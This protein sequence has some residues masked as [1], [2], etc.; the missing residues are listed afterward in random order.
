MSPQ[1]IKVQKKIKQKRTIFFRKW[2]RRIGFTAALFLINLAVTGIILIH[3]EFMSLHKKFISNSLL[4]DWYG[5]KSPT[6]L[7][8][9]KFSTLNFCK[10]ENEIYA[11]NEQSKVKNLIDNFSQAIYVEQHSDNFV[12][13]DSSTIT[14]FTKDLQRIDT[15][16]VKEEYNESIASASILKSTLVI[17]TTTQKLYFDLDTFEFIDKPYVGL[18]DEFVNHVPVFQVI[19]NQ[20]LEEQQ[21]KQ[22]VAQ[23]YREQQITLLKFVQDLHSGQIFTSNGKLLMDLTAIILIL[24]TIS[25]FITWQRRKTRTL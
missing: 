25:G 20:S 21:L 8:C 12:F 19:N 17:S 3:F 15:V 24:L 4:L 5:V 22:L 18:T 16:N 9:K 7:S 23:H 6:T 11:I 2:H 1:E 13:I 10:L 14:F